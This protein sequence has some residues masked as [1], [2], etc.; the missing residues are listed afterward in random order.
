MDINR[1]V[2]N[3]QL[4]ERQF[5]PNILRKNVWNIAWQK[6][7]F[8]QIVFLLQYTETL[9]SFDINVV[10]YRRRSWTRLLNTTWTGGKHIHWIGYFIPFAIDSYITYNVIICLLFCIFLIRGPTASR[11]SKAYYY[12]YF[13]SIYPLKTYCTF[14]WNVL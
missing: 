3:Q 1:L 4:Y 7:Q 2:R 5:L 8:T 6:N 14:W 12:C 13:L 9:L 11:P 10:C